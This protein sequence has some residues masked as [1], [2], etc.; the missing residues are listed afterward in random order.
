[1]HFHDKTPRKLE[2]QWNFLN[3]IND[4][5]EKSTANTIFNGEKTKSFSPIIFKKSI[6]LFS[7]VPLT[8]YS[9]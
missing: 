9:E 6:L 1:M 2:I 5:Y 3:M 4:I 7:L 8:L